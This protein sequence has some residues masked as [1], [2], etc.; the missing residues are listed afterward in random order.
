MTATDS[1]A[2]DT[3][4]RARPVYDFN[5][6]SGSHVS[7][8]MGRGLAFISLRATVHKGEQTLV[9]RKDRFCQSGMAPLSAKPNVD[10]S[11]EIIAVRVPP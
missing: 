3:D 8:A 2:R 6:N 9:T 4:P 11:G 5:V 10:E 1:I 7:A